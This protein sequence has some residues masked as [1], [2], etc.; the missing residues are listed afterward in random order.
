MSALKYQLKD[1]VS[2]LAAEANKIK[3]PNVKR[4]LY[5]IKAVCDSKK[6]I[7]KTCEVRGFSTDYFYKWCKRFLEAKSLSGLSTRPKTVKIF[8]NKTDRRVERK[9]IRLRKKEPFKGPERISFEL[10]NKFKIICAASTV[11]AILK[12]AGLVTKKYRESLTKKHMKRYRR[13]WPGYLQMDFK[14]TPYLLDGR[15]T[16]QL[17]AID[18]HSS[19]RFIRNYEN[20]SLKTVMSFLNELEA[21]AP[22]Y[23]IQIQTDNATE[24]TDKYSS[25]NK[26]LKPTE[27]HE[28]DVWCAARGIEHKL[29][30]IGEKELNGKVEN[31]H[32]W[33]DRE[34]FS[35]IKITTYAELKAAT[36]EYNLHWNEARPTKTLGWLT[37]NEVMYEAGVRAAAYLK[38]ILPQSAWQRPEKLRR[39][40][41]QGGGEIIAPKSEIKKIRKS[42]T[43]Q[44]K[45]KLLSIIDRYL[46]YLDW[47]DKQKIKFWVPVSMILQ[48]FSLTTPLISQLISQQ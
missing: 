20:R 17:S 19:W 26:G 31:S 42:M 30:P 33:D 10:R 41:T 16:Y 36:I 7:K 37:P 25:F 34:F 43:P 39:I 21:A 15:Q 38:F 1:L 5:L 6:D 48:N 27:A 46:K 2:S 14:Y 47:E 4:R 45:P 29:I 13:P 35:Q 12:R 22:F 23:I 8:W 32:K 18:H 3:D 40:T 9:I 24:F 44:K 11:A 28:V